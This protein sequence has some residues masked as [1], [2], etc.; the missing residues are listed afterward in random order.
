MYPLTAL[1]DR[2]QRSWAGHSRFL[3]RLRGECVLGPFPATGARWP[4]LAFSSLNAHLLDL[5]LYLKR[6]SS[7]VH[8]CVPISPFHKDICRIDEGHPIGLILTDHLCMEPI[9]KQGHVLQLWGLGFPIDLFCRDTIQ[10]TAV[11]ISGR[12]ESP[13]T[14]GRY[15]HRSALKRKLPLELGAWSPHWPDPNPSSC[16]LF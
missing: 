8:V 1:E 7:H 5:W 14:S 16:Y 11:G 10:P 9:P 13:P 4:S 6:C 12:Q 15:Q 3:L 2:G